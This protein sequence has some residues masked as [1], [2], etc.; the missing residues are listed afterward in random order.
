MRA[1]ALVRLQLIFYI[2]PCTSRNAMIQRKFTLPP[3]IAGQIKYAPEPCFCHHILLLVVENCVTSVFNNLLHRILPFLER[4]VLHFYFDA[5]G[6]NPAFPLCLVN[7]L[8][9]ME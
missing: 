8:F 7:A 6:A 9:Q 4:R 2:L 3:V 1:S 5:G